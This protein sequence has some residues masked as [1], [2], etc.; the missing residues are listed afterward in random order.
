MPEL[1]VKSKVFLVYQKVQRENPKPTLTYKN[2]SYQGQREPL[3]LVLRSLNSQ[4]VVPNLTP[5]SSKSQPIFI[6]HP[7]F[8]RHGAKHFV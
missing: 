7:L 5:P 3:N 8:I 2:P 4:N 1:L 6:W